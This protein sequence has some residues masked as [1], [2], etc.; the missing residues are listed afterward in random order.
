MAASNA[1]DNLYFMASDV[2][3]ATQYAVANNNPATFQN[4]DQESGLAQENFS[5]R[6]VNPEYIS[7]Y[8][9]TAPL[10]DENDVVYFEDNQTQQ[11]NSSQPDIDVYNNFSVNN[12][13]N[14]RGWRNT[15]FN[16]GFGFGGF[17]GFSP[18]SMGFYDPFF[19]PFWGF[20]PG[21]N[22]GLNFGFGRPFYDPFNPFFGVG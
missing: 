3:I 14:N 4:L 10:N 5:S 8:G 17:G 7:R 11:T 21:F 15:A 22:V 18:F 9:Q 6:N 1:N 20:R 12:F 19:D 13:G 2:R 16:M